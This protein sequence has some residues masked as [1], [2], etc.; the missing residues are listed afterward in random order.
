MMLPKFVVY[1]QSP[2]RLQ[3][4]WNVS[5]ILGYLNLFDMCCLSA[6]TFSEQCYVYTYR[7]KVAMPYFQFDYW[8]IG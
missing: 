2:Y 7:R 5:F 1:V 3:L 4:I 8:A 6:W